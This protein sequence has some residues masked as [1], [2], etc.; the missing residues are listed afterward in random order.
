MIQAVNFVTLAT[1]LSEDVIKM[2]CALVLGDGL[3]P[4]AA[5]GPSG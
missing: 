5:Q 2:E 1:A 4:E 3:L